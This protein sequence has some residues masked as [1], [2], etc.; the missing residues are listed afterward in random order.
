MSF[1]ASYSD[2]WEM[3]ETV[4]RV[5]GLGKRY[6]VGERERSRAARRAGARIEGLPSGVTASRSSA[7]YFW[8]LRDVS[9]GLARR[10]CRAHRAERRRQDHAAEDPLPDHAPDDGSAE[11]RG[12]VGSLLEVGTGFHPDSRGAKTYT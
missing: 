9:F 1:K 2:Y 11:I 6:C 12:R 5:E 8:A 10:G 4:I 3:S 7:D